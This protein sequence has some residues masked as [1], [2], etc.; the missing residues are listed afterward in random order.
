V[1]AIDG[2][3]FHFHP[4]LPSAAGDVISSAGGK[5]LAA[6]FKFQIAPSLP[7]QHK[8]RPRPSHCS[9]AD[10]LESTSATRTSQS[11]STDGNEDLGVKAAENLNIDITPPS[12]RDILL[13]P[14]KT[15]LQPSNLTTDG[16]NPA[17]SP[18]FTT[19]GYGGG[20]TSM[21]RHVFCRHAPHPVPVMLP[22]R[23]L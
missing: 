5:P 4:D 12:Y 6:R 3:I 11:L 8:K 23:H 21:G 13:R 20:D 2:V 14:P 9:D 18:R 16:D 22:R 1:F 7:A 15:T 19:P 17:Y 10:H